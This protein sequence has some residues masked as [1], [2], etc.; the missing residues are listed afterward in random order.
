MIDIG[1]SA[2]KWADAQTPENTGIIQYGDMVALAEQVRDF[3]LKQGPELIY[4]CT[5]ANSQIAKTVQTVCHAARVEWLG[6]QQA[7][8]GCFRMR[9]CYD[10]YARLGADRWY[11]ALGAVAKHPGRNLLVVQMGTALT[12]DAVRF[13]K[14]REYSFLGGRIAPGPT[15]MFNSLKQ[16]AARLSQ[17]ST[18]RWCAFPANTDDAISSGIVNCVEGFIRGGVDD[19][20]RESPPLIVVTGGAATFFRPVLEHFF[21]GYVHEDNLVITGLS[22]RIRS[23]A[24]Q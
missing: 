12:A 5:V 6:S 20:P 24:C 1:N 8:E 15:M 3:C 11:A 17:I 19:F 14:D 13:E 7:F 16:G 21:K 4:A 2:L 10:N 9:N 22:L 18:G 23:E